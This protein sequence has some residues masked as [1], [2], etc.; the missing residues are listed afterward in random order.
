MHVY[1]LTYMETQPYSIIL[2]YVAKM[3]LAHT[4]WLHMLA[5]SI[6]VAYDS[7]LACD[8]SI[9][10]LR[11][12]ICSQHSQHEGNIFRM[13]RFRYQPTDLFKDFAFHIGEPKKNV[14]IL[15]EC[16][17]IMCYGRQQIFVKSESWV[18]DDICQDPCGKMSASRS[19]GHKAGKHWFS[20]LVS[21]VRSSSLVIL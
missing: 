15:V 10:L 14:I 5:A 17:R 13:L 8:P 20:N 12:S 1:M 7:I 18:R 19:K 4:I 2:L 11:A 3:I 9:C 6:S 16:Q 21:F